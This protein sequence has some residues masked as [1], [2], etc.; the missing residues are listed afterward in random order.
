MAEED[1]QSLEYTPTWILAGVCFVIVF[2]SFGV[3]RALH[4]L[5]KFLKHKE[6][7]AL[8]EALQKLKEELML[9][10][11]ISLMLS[12]TQ[13]LISHMCIPRYLT[14]HMLP[15]KRK[16]ESSPEHYIPNDDT[17]PPAARWNG[18]RL[19]SEGTDVMYCTNKGKVQLLSLEALHQLHIF[20]FV[21]ALVHVIFC[22][23]TM[24]LGGMKI[25][26]W[27]KWEDSIRHDGSEPGKTPGSVK[28]AHA[29]PHLEFF[30]LR[31]V[32]FWRKSVVISWIM[33]VPSHDDFNFH[34]YMMRTL[35]V[36][37]KKVVGIRWYLW[38]FVVIFLLLNV[39]GWHSYFWLSFLPMILLLL[40]GAKL[41]HI[42]SKLAEEVAERKTNDP[43]ALPMNPSDKHFWF[44]RPAIVLYLIHFILFQNAFE[45]AFFFWILSTYGFTS[46][47]MEK[48][49]FI[50]PRLII[51]LIIQVLCSYI[52]LPLYAIVT[53]MGSKYK[54][55]FL[56]EP[57][58]STLQRWVEDTKSR[59][60]LGFGPSHGSSSHGVEMQRRA[61]ET[62]GSTDTTEWLPVVL[63][64]ITTSLSE[65][66]DANQT[67]S[68]S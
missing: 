48:G 30:R 31:A 65:C 67:R 19:L 60:R 25:R 26:E 62:F 51:G 34:K 36:D 2:I 28:D 38:L 8:F 56:P 57:V 63:E 33:H 22:A 50:I 64:G 4:H 59:K 61:S 27:K 37:F 29:H 39:E 42:I 40:V 10:G 11:F 49:R 45:I 9:L 14:T 32:G 12:V 18:R 16:A 23:T 52:T 41:E 1:I 15:C 53:Q 5:G 43:R 68:P 46:C 66:S 20:I 24:V 35:E 44:G 17:F 47:I 21:L 6:Q 13:G 7:D 54:Q 58:E 55:G 3:E